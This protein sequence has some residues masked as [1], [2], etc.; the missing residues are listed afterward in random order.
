MQGENGVADEIY[1]YIVVG[2]GSAG[3]AVAGRLSEDG[4]QRVLLLEAGPADTNPWIHLPIGY[5]RTFVDERV[6]WKYETEPEPHLDNRK[7]YWPRGKTLGGSSSIN[8]LI[9]IRGVPSDYDY[10]RQLGN[11][12]WGWDD[13]LPHFR[14]AERN[15]R[16]EDALHGGSG[17]LGVEE[18]R[19]RNGLS[20]AWLE[21]ALQ[22]GVKR[23]PDFNGAEQE[24]AGYYQFTVWGGRRCSAARAYLGP[25]KSRRNL[26]IVTGA[27]TD[28]VLVENGRAT[29]VRYTLG[30]GAGARSE[31]ARAAREVVLCGG[32][33][34]TPQ[35][36]LL[37]GIGPA[38]HLQE[39]GIPVVHAVRG[40]GENLHDHLQ[41]KSVY[42]ASRPATYNDITK[43]NLRK[44]GIGLR[45]MLTRGGPLAVGA[46]LVGVFAR[47][48]PELA[49]PDVQM[50][51][52][53]WS[54]DT[55][56]TELHP[57]PG[58]SVVVNQSR[59][60]SRGRLRLRSGDP[61][62]PPSM[63]A[64]YLAEEV[65]RQ[66]VVAGLKLMRRIA[67]Q[68]AL[69]PWLDVELMPGPDVHTDAEFLGYARQYG[70]SI[71]H[72]VGTCRMG[73]EH[74]AMAVVD[75]RLR[76]RGIA[77]L[78]VADASVMPQVISGNTNA[79]CITIGEKA[80]EMMRQDRAERL[81]A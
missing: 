57:F 40:V 28:R 66:A 79:A 25:A 30:Q 53:P 80:A 55:M 1:D 16:G 77:G 52:T 18:P 38:E 58:F 14:R 74:D 75:A 63:L 49:D 39:I 2:A 47:T 29:G 59:P 69:A 36:L 33:L 3:C 7:I 32:A 68:K 8:G 64:N 6:N 35:L 22:A 10:W 24:G 51:F 72:P 46:G 62:Q 31:T 67:E 65:D 81:A 45:W 44:A 9:Y 56:G 61:R 73:P 76:L 50:H 15:E 20:D 12:G 43:G 5:A 23:N 21:A 13:L 26:R 70:A 27:L 17:P 71:Y 11:E 60:Q 54:T 37:S 4:S 42:R 41:V 19:W 48:R 34:N 78:R